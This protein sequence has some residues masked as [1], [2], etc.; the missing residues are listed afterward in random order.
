MINKLQI[1]G[2]LLTGFLYWPVYLLDH[3]H[4][5]DKIILWFGL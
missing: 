2:A 1:I 3:F 4:V 5:L